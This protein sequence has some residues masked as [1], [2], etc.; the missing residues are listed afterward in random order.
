M[1]AQLLVS[2]AE[3]LAA[4]LLASPAEPMGAELLASLVEPLGAGLRDSSAEPM[5]AELLASLVEPL[6]AGLRDSSAEPLIADPL[7]SPAE[8]LGAELLDSPA[9]PRGALHFAT[10]LLWRT[11]HTHHH[12][13]RRLSTTGI[14]CLVWPWQPKTE[15]TNY[16]EHGPALPFNIGDGVVVARDPWRSRTVSGWWCLSWR[17]HEWHWSKPGPRAGRASRLHGPW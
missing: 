4:E 3:P 8:P 17:D 7:A 2:S 12:Q 15:E 5:G 9:E 16:G 13:N 1:G 11:P 14:N 6:G 10:D